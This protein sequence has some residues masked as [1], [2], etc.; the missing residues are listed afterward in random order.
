MEKV[1]VVEP[2]NPENTGMIARL[3]AN[4]DAG[5]ELVNPGFNLEEARD[6][7]VDAQKKLREARI[8][9]GLEEIEG[10]LV[11]SKPGE[12]DVEKFSFPRETV[13][14]IGR[15]SSGLSN[16][17]LEKCDASVGIDTPGKDSLNQATAAAVLMH[18]ASKEGFKV[19]RDRLDAVERKAGEEVAEL[20]LRAE[21]SEKELDKLLEAL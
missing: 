7:A 1:V 9:E 3:C 8:R 13:L 15:E 19:D 11:G 10:F 2:E 20:A 4:F 17:E 18:Q 16:S 21:A 6:T 12:T 14:V 5:L